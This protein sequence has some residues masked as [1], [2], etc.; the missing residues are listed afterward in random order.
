MIRSVT[1][2]TVLLL[3]ENY[4]GDSNQNGLWKINSD[5]TGLMRLTTDTQNLQ[6]LCPFTQYAWSNISRDESMYALQEHDQ[7]N[8]TY[9]MY[10]GSLSGGQPTEFANISG[11]ELLLAGWTSL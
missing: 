7:K 2:T 4:S 5:G 11:T 9:N 6:S 10:Y 3:I 8:N 1:M